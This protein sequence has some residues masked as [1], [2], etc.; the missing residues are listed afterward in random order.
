MFRYTN[1]PSKK[2]D[3]LFFRDKFIFVLNITVAWFLP[4]GKDFG[5]II[6]KPID[7]VDVGKKVD[8]IKITVGNT[9]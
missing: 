2:L 4:I 8:V 5:I 9:D 3:D 6:V 1:R 7:F